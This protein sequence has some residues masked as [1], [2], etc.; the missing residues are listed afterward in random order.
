MRAAG[1]PKPSAEHTAHHTVSGKGRTT[2]MARTRLHLHTVAGVGIND[3]DNGAWMPRNS[4]FVPHWAS[5]EATPHS[6]IHT[7]RYERWIRDK[8]TVIYSPQGVRTKLQI[9][10]RMLES[11]TQP[12]EVAIPKTHDK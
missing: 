11:G 12:R 8:I 6:K 2:A 4:K 7:D 5:L 1:R 10:G 9:L 3:P